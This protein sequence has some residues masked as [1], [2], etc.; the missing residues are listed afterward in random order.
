MPLVKS[1]VLLKVGKGWC[2]SDEA[3][4]DNPLSCVECS[5]VNECGCQLD[6]PG[7][8]IDRP[9]HIHLQAACSLLV[10]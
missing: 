10:Q 2:T 4:I 7:L 1:V 5:D 8:A 3:G 6:T 9:L